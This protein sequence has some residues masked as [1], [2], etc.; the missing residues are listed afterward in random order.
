[1]KML[2]SRM[3]LATS[4][5]LLLNFFVQLLIEGPLFI[6]ESQLTCEIQSVLGLGELRGRG[7]R[8]GDGLFPFVQ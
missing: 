8:L 2:M 6:V 7:I 5:A 1:M 3:L 4:V